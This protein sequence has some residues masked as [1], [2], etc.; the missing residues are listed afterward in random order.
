MKSH[1]I[2]VA[3][4]QPDWIERG[5]QEYQK[6]LPKRLFL[7]ETE[8]KPSSGSHLSLNSD[9]MKERESERISLALQTLSKNNSNT[10]VWALDE[11]GALWTTSEWAQQLEKAQQRGVDLAW[12]IGGADGLSRPFK[13]QATQLIALSRLTLPHGL[14]KVILAE[15]IYRA[16]SLITHH[17]YHRS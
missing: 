4:K 5:F 6:R 1:L 10:E 8:L 11:T 17:P 2:C 14:V 13:Q 16:H 9:A 3:H 12:I 15:Q 7:H